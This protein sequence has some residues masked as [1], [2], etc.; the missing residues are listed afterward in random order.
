MYVTIFFI[1]Y[2]VTENVICSYC[3]FMIYTRNQLINYC[4]NFVIPTEDNMNDNPNFSISLLGVKEDKILFIGY[5]LIAYLKLK[6][7][8]TTYPYCNFKEYC[9]AL[10]T[11]FTVKDLI[12]KVN[13]LNVDPNEITCDKLNISKD[14]KRVCVVT[15]QLNHLEPNQYE[16]GMFLHENHKN[17]ACFNCI[18]CDYC[19]FCINCKDCEKI[20]YWKSCNNYH[21]IKPLVNYQWKKIYLERNLFNFSFFPQHL[22]TVITDEDIFIVDINSDGWRVEAKGDTMKVYNEYDILVFEGPLTYRDS[23]KRIEDIILCKGKLYYDDGLLDKEGYFG[24]NEY[25][26][27]SLIDFCNGKSIDKYFMGDVYDRHGKKVGRV[28]RY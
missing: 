8:I 27:V 20:H 19:H 5:Y 23:K 2:Y 3:T 9:H 26:F 25:N 12:V 21:P 24:K 7:E 10:C 4:C 13:D 17:M 18:R 11:F 15:R 28:E 22:A 14:V 16:S 1:N 6:K